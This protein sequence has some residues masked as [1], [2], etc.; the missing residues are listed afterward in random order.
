M[1]ELDEI[2]KGLRRIS[3]IVS[4]MPQEQKDG[5]YHESIN[6]KSPTWEDWN[7]KSEDDELPCYYCHTGSKHNG[8]TSCYFCT[9]KKNASD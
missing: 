4:R 9:K 7:T 1:E 5:L 3:K 8:K 2:L 6:T